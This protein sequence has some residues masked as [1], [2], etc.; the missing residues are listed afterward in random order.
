VLYERLGTY[1]LHTGAQQDALAALRRAVSLVPPR[2]ASAARARAMAWLGYALMDPDHYSESLETST[3]ALAIAEEVGDDRAALLAMS[4]SGRALSCLGR[5]VEGVE[6]L[7]LARRRAQERGT[8]EELTRIYILL[9]DVLITAGK[10][11]EAIRVAT[12]GLAVAC[13]HGMERSHG[14]ALRVN[15]ANA[16][17]ATGAWSQA[18]QVLNAALRTVG[19]FWTHHPHL[20][21]ARLDIGRG[22]YTSARHHLD[23]GAQAVDKLHAAA[24]H[25]YLTAELALWQARPDDA[26]RAVDEGLGRVHGP[27]PVH[28][29][30]GLWVQGLR[31]DVDLAQRAA[32]NRDPTMLR[33]VHQHASR[34]I[35]NVRETATHADTYAVEAGAWRAQAE[36]EYER[37]VDRLDPQLWET[38]VA[39][40][41][42]VERPYLAAYCRWRQ[43]ESLVAAQVPAVVA[44][45]PAREAHRVARWLGARPLRDELEQFAARARLDLEGLTRPP[46]ETQ[47]PDGNP[48]GL[49]DRERD[50]LQLLSR[51][52]TNRDI[53]TELTIS[54]KT[55]S[56]HVSNILR[57]LNART[58]VE[59]AAIAHRLLPRRDAA[60]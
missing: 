6:R 51:G 33:Q 43:A 45:T 11:H 32:I 19:T 10:S 36:A 35:E 14:V 23:A 12:E 22:D 50:V 20:F 3:A 27:V 52:Y 58:R 16:Y 2:P 47:P 55:A 53:G 54:A 57:K 7:H 59:A 29:Q 40:W 37:V 38:A 8:P 1:L 9:S 30:L 46:G 25:A 15:A 13:R 24:H 4:V 44:A 48:L 39:A 49:T 26:V 21:Q 56:V 60:D 5:T 31:A 18:E 42:A 41:D 28:E 34:L 17:L